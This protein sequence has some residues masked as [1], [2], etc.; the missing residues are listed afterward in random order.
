MSDAVPAAAP[1]LT[2]A[3]K[4]AILVL[5]LEWAQAHRIAAPH[6]CR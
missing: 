1:M 5:L 3:Q 2:G 6:G 4:C